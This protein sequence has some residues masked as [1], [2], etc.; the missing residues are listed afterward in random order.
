MS[1]LSN[2]FLNLSDLA[3][4]DLNHLIKLGEKFKKGYRINLIKP[5]YVANLFFENSTRTHTSFYMAESKLGLKVV[6]INTATSSVKKGESLSDTVK[7]LQSLGIS[8]EVIRHKTTGWYSSIVED[9][10]VNASIVNAGDGA[11]QHPSQS[12]LDLMTIYEEFGTFEGLNVGIIGDL[13]HSRVAKSDAQIL[14]KLGANL[15]FSGPKE[16]YDAE[17]SDYGTYDSFDNIIDKL[18]ITMLLRVQLER[19]NAD[20][21]NQFK[22]NEYHEQFGLS[23]DRANK[24]KKSAIIMHPAPVN[25]GVEIDSSLVESSQSRIF[26]QMENGVFARMAILAHILDNKNL[27]AEE[28]SYE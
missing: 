19:L 21:V 3:I 10:N 18:D 14:H 9:N 26:K 16:W 12:L 24:M 5:V 23:L 1:N 13:S 2:N 11:G 28:I 15:Y 7:T 8:I 6:D 25:R 20:S 22:A 4:E 17:F 27:L